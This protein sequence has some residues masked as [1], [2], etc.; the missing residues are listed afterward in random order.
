MNFGITSK[1]FMVF[2]RCVVWHLLKS[3]LQGQRDNNN[4]L[5]IHRHEGFQILSR[6]RI[7]WQWTQEQHISSNDTVTDFYDNCSI[8]CYNV[9]C[10]EIQF[11]IRAFGDAVGTLF[12]IL[13]I[14]LTPGI[15]NIRSKLNKLKSS[16]HIQAHISITMPSFIPQ[17]LKSEYWEYILP[18]NNE[19]ICIFTREIP[20]ESGI[21]ISSLLSHKNHGVDNTG[22]VRVWAAEQALLFKAGVR[23]S[24]NDNGKYLNILFKKENHKIQDILTPKDLRVF[25]NTLS[26]I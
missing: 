11:Y 19:H 20:R 5:S 14:G 8:A 3:A 12:R 10:A 21:K 26:S 2:E 6:K 13:H 16:L 23:F 22:M 24:L 4:N 17:T 15:T 18:L 7:F 1:T 25:C 9:D